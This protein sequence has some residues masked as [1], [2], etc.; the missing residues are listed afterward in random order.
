MQT[1]QEKHLENIDLQ[2]N[3]IQN[4]NVSLSINQNAKEKKS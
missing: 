3:P 2:R 1:K 4:N